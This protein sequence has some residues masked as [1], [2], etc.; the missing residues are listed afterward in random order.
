MS[1]YLSG[2]VRQ[3]WIENPRQ[4][5]SWWDMEQFSARGFFLAGVLIENLKNFSQ[6]GALQVDPAKPI[7]NYSAPVSDDIRSRAIK[8]FKSI[9]DQCK[10]IGLA[11]S[12]DM[13]SEARLKL[14]SDAHQLL[15]Y[16]WLRDKVF[17]FR[18][19]VGREM[20]EHAF[21]YIGPNKMKYWPDRNSRNAYGD[22]VADA[23]GSTYFDAGQAGTCLA[24]GLATASV[25]HVM[26]T[27]EIALSSFGAIFGVSLAH[28]NWAPA[29]DEI[30]KKIRG[31]RQDPTWQQNPD[32]KALQEQYSQAASYFGVVKDAWRNYTMHIRAK[33]TEDEAELI[34]LNVRSFMQKLAALGIKEQL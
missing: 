17:D 5:M 13:I 25:F 22:E 6:M 16:Q 32:C 10:S 3:P 30:E 23:F 20:R 11:I 15:N 28:T 33:Y 31:M 24:I 19:L 4:L 29:L 18:S 1:E 34:Y 12:A 21:F 14:E 27:L 9:E 26:R 7:Y 2:A 8:G